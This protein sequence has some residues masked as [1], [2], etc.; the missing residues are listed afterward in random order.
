MTKY[1]YRDGTENTKYKVFPSDNPKSKRMFSHTTCWLCNGTAFLPHYA[2]VD[3]GVCYTCKGHGA[4]RRQVWTKEQI[5]KLLEKDKIK[6]EKFSKDQEDRKEEILAEQEKRKEEE[7]IAEEKRLAEIEDKLAKQ[8]YI[9]SIG[10]KIELE[11][12]IVFSKTFDGYYGQSTIYSLEDNKGNSLVYWQSGY[13]KFPTMEKK[14]KDGT[15]LFYNPP[16]GEKFLIKATVKEHKVYEN[17]FGKTK[18]T[19]LA[20]PKNIQDVDKQH[21]QDIGTWK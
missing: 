18:Q 5:E 16:K 12:K 10:D 3:N 13:G 1:F 20:R 7:K 17:N 21:W 14:E 6:N 4:H 2:H 19:V 11:V 8:E 9:G 15:L